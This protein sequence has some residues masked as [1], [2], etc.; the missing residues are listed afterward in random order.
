MDP[1]LR[2]FPHRLFVEYQRRGSGAGKMGETGQAASAITLNRA[3]AGLCSWTMDIAVD[4]ALA[5]VARLTVEDAPN[6]PDAYT[7]AQWREWWIDDTSVTEIT[8]MVNGGSLQCIANII[9]TNRKSGTGVTN[10]RHTIRQKYM[11]AVLNVL[12]EDSDTDEA[13]HVAE[14]PIGIYFCQRVDADFG[15]AF[16]AVVASTPQN[17]PRT[18]TASGTFTLMQTSRLATAGD[19]TSAMLPVGGEVITST[20]SATKRTLLSGEQAY[21]LTPSGG[22]AGITHIRAT[23]EQALTA[24]QLMIRSKPIRV[25]DN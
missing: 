18:A 16:P 8:N 22:S 12:Y 3:Q 6:A 5:P 11:Q 23:G 24:G 4:G 19:D 14:N 9:P 21:I 15:Y 25:E 20:D 13:N 10:V 2:Q 17:S 1:I 7:D